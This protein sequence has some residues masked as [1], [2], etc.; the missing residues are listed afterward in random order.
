MSSI[1][2]ARMLLAA[3]SWIVLCKVALAAEPAK[4]PA[5][6]KWEKTITAFEEDDRKSPPPPGAVLFVG[7]SSIRLWNLKQ[8]FPELTTLNRG[9]GGSQMSDAAAFARRIVTPY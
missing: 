3:L 2:P 8:S 1:L 9:F 6:S 7:S 5:T 4:S